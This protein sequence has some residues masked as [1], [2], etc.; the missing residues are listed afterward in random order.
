MADSSSFDMALR[1][2]KRK[3]RLLDALEMLYYITLPVL[4]AT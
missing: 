3:N 4:K 2:D 1:E